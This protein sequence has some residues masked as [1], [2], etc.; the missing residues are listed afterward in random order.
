MYSV[1]IKLS[2]AGSEK[3]KKN[4]SITNLNNTVGRRE[5]IRPTYS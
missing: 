3:K 2:Y 4:E 5:Q 1:N